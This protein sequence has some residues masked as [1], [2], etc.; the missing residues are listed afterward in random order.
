MLKINI[1]DEITCK[2]SINKYSLFIFWSCVS[3]SHPL[4]KRE[5]ERNKGKRVTDSDSIEGSF[6]C[7]SPIVS[8]NQDAVTR[9]IC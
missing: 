9:L 3:A 7:V 1:F 4:G 6:F 8:K 5:E 2:D